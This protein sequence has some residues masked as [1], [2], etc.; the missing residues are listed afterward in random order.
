MA[1]TLTGVV[2]SD[3]RDKT[4]TVSIASRETHP[5]YRKQYTKTRK[6]TAHDANNEAKIGD[7]VVISEI[8]PISKTKTWKLDKIL[9]RSHGKVE[10]KEEVTGEVVKE[11]K[12]A[13]EG[14]QK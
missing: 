5:L 13:A 1:T 3:K 11:E 6:Y 12:A 10:L 2:S 7:K 9:E 14:D 4:I 8:R